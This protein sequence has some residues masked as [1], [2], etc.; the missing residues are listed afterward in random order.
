MKWRSPIKAVKKTLTKPKV[1]HQIGKRY[2]NDMDS[3]EGEARYNREMAKSYKSTFWR[4][5]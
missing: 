4:K 1:D 3:E 2:G 5:A